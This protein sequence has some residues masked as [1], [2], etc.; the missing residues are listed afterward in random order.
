M[1]KKFLG[2]FAICLFLLGIVGISNASIVT[3]GITGGAALSRGGEF[4]IIDPIPEGLTVGNDNFQD[5][6]LRAFNEDQNTIL[7]SALVVDVGTNIAAGTEVSSHYIVFDPAVTSVNR[8]VYGYVEFNSNVLGIVTTT[9]S[10]AASD[11][12]ANNDVT[13]LNPSLR[14]LESEDWASIDINNPKRINLYLNASSPGDCIRVITASVPIP[15]AV[16]L[17]GSSLIGMLGFRKKLLK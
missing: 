17:L 6:N 2:A 4:I 16:W 12:L 5:V 3:G 14:G 13:Y 9:S 10:L 15:G 11:V 7:S 1:I 8:D